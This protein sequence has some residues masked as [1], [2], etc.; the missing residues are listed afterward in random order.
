ML[1]HA[2]MVLLMVGAV[3]SA[4]GG[5]RLEGFL[6]AGRSLAYYTATATPS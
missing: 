5:N 4:L 2:G 1:V 6:A 3:W